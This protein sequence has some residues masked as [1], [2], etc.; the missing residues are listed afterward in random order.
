MFPFFAVVV[1]VLFLHVNKR[2]PDLCCVS[3]LDLCLCHWSCLSNDLLWLQCRS[4]GAWCFVALRML[5]VWMLPH[6]LTW[7]IVKLYRLSLCF[8]VIW[9]FSA[10]PIHCY[11]AEETRRR[12]NVLDWMRTDCSTWRKLSPV[13]DK[14]PSS[15]ISGGKY[16][17]QTSSSLSELL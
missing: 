3:T 1:F 6:S 11:S 10:P 8:H 12:M 4:A 2:C 9:G 13:K 16:L 17:K 15:Y 5:T 14:F 7:Q